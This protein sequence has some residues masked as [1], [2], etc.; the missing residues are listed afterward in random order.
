MDLTHL[1]PRKDYWADFYNFLHMNPSD[2]QMKNAGPI[3]H[4]FYRIS[5]KSEKFEFFT[6]CRYIFVPPGINGL[7]VSELLE[8]LESHLCKHSGCFRPKLCILKDVNIWCTHEVCK[9]T[10]PA[11]V[12]QSL[13]L[14]CG[15]QGSI[16]LS[17]TRQTWIS[18]KN[19]LFGASIKGRALHW[20]Y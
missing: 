11:P 5:S 7:M 6:L 14:S 16:R 2:D 19:I 9:Q 20:A 4:D 12:V 13:S 10:L 8:N 1:C 17:V 15:L 18:R 3:I